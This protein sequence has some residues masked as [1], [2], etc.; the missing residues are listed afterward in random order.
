MTRRRTLATVGLTGAAAL[1]VGGAAL[2]GAAAAT[3]DDATTGTVVD[4]VA[5]RVERIAEALGGLV[6]DGTITED[7]ADTVAE[8]LAESDAL[9]GPGGHGGHGG[10][11]WPG[12]RLLALDSAAETLGLTADELRTA[13]EEDGA[14]LAS[15][16][17]EQGVGRDALVEALVDAARTHLEDEVAEGDLTQ[18]QADELGADLQA[19]VSR[20]VDSE[21]AGLGSGGPAGHHGP[22]GGTVEDRT[23]SGTTTPSPSASTAA[24]DV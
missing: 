15:V 22:R 5:E 6:D 8:T 17:E 11:G 10:H 3:T 4:R 24:L 9:R 7:Q 21:P 1:V 13:L 14:S 12:G 16:A 2:T 18:E 19:R 23:D 20:L